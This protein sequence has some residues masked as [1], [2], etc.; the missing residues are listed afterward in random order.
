MDNE[1]KVGDVLYFRPS[2]QN[3]FVFAKVSKLDLEDHTR[4]HL[5][6]DDGITLFNRSGSWWIC[7]YMKVTPDT[8]QN[9]LAVQLKYQG[10]RGAH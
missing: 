6:D 3:N 5:V 10:Q 4:V 8:P 2:D 9:R 7:D 1:F